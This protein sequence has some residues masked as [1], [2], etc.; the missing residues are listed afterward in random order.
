M[1]GPEDLDRPALR[2]LGLGQGASA[3][4]AAL[5]SQ[6]LATAIVTRELGAEGYGTLSLAGAVVGLLVLLGGF[7]LSQQVARGGPNVGRSLWATSWL[8]GGATAALLVGL[9][10]A[11]VGSTALRDVMIVFVPVAGLS[12]QFGVLVGTAMAEGRRGLATT[13]VNF[14]GASKFVAVAVVVLTVPKPD[15]EVF[16]AV[17]S[18][19]LG[20]AFILGGWKLRADAWPWVPSVVALRSA[21]VGAASL[22]PLAASAVMLARLDI[23]MVGLFEDAASVGVFQIAVRLSE[24]PFE[25]YAGALVMFVAGVGLREDGDELAAWYEGVTRLLAAAL[26]PV[27]VALAVFGDVVANVV[28]G[29]DVSGPPALYAIAAIGIAAQ[30][31]TGPNGAVLVARD[32]RRALT[33][34]ALGLITLDLVLNLLLIP[35]F[36]VIG[37]ALATSA[38]YVVVNLA[39][40]ILVRQHVGD[41]LLSGRWGLEMG[42]RTALPVALLLAIRLWVAPALVSLGLG[43]ATVLLLAVHGWRAHGRAPTL[44]QAGAAEPPR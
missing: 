35:P 31:A 40:S 21:A 18:M 33:A 26:I 44:N 38:A 14:V 7:Q 12:P 17:E 42:V 9:V 39:S 29:A 11:G 20:A 28:F 6:T 32:R 23:T 37:A 34:V 30:I 36:G 43:A 15:P 24:V 16:A 41:W 27:V 25:L 5:A 2:E 1:T 3:R 8:L 13:L 10:S 19:L 4:L 22:L